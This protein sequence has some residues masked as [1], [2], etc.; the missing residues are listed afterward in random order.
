[1]CCRSQ[2]EPD[3]DRITSSDRPSSVSLLQ[4]WVRQ[5]GGSSPSAGHQKSN[6]QKLQ[7][8]CVWVCQ[9]ESSREGMPRFYGSKRIQAGEFRTGAV[10]LGWCSRRESPASDAN[11]ISSFARALPPPL[12]I[13][14]NESRSHRGRDADGTSHRVWSA[15][16]RSNG[17]TPTR[18]VS[19]LPAGFA[20]RSRDRASRRPFVRC[21]TSLQLCHYSSR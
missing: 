6:P 1:L 19:G 13:R 12:G 7:N 16:R 17:S 18:L 8:H 3:P 14:S 11:L 4:P 5:T 15:T 10:G 21:P 20:C 2:V 9:R